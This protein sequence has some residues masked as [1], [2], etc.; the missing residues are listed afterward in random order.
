MSIVLAESVA[1]SKSKL[2]KG[3]N[4][5]SINLDGKVVSVDGAD[6]GFKAAGNVKP[7]YCAVVA[8]S[9]HKG[10]A[11][12]AVTAFNDYSKNICENIEDSYQQFDTYFGDMSAVIEKCEIEG[13]L[14]SIGAIAICDNCVAAAKKGNAHILR[15][16]DGDL[17]EIAISEADGGNGYQ[18]INTVNNGDIFAVVSEEASENLDYDGIIN[19]FDSGKDLK[20]MANDFISLL[21]VDAGKDCTVVLIK[22]KVKDIPVVAHAPVAAPADDLNV[23]FSASTD[24][25]AAD[26]DADDGMLEDYQTHSLNMLGKKKMLGLIPIVVLVVI[27]AVVVGYYVASNVDFSGNENPSDNADIPVFDDSTDTETTTEN[28]SESVVDTE[29]T[30]AEE[31][32]TAAEEETTASV[33][34]DTTRA[35][36]T[37][38][39]APETT[40]KAPET[41]TKAPETT[42]KAPETTTKAPETTTKAPETTTKAPETTTERP[43]QTPPDWWDVDLPY[44]G[45]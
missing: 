20:S 36:E 18:L 19:I 32:T 21:P 26:D 9:N 35:P 37:T 40:T 33:E 6:K 22:L 24:S 44:Y 11:N 10:F 30:T 31:E 28:A 13:S 12:G 34:D 7:P 8:S 4:G 38:T 43:T 2:A 16:S 23:D 42:T 45:M 14:L 3:F 29:T 39:K 25:I 1:V 41:T 17:F 27:L 5:D 15:F